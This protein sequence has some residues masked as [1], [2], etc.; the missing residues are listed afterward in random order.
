M[1]L[2]NNRTGS[3]SN[4][5]WRFCFRLLSTGEAVHG[6]VRLRSVRLGTATNGHAASTGRLY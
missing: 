4:A 3:N 6:Y 2:P 1:V 5:L